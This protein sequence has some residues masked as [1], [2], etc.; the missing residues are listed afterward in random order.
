MNH[1]IFR[2]DYQDNFTKIANNDPAFDT[3][4]PIA[5]AVWHEL[6]TK[7]KNWKVI[8]NAIAKKARMS[9]YS[10]K[11]A[12]QELKKEG[13]LV[14]ERVR[15]NLGRWVE[16]AC[17]FKQTPSIP[18][19][20]LKKSNPPSEPVRSTSRNP[21]A[22]VSTAGIL[23]AL[24]IYKESNTE[25]NK[26][27][28]ISTS[29]TP[30]TRDVCDSF[31]VFETSFFE[32]DSEPEPCEDLES[33]PTISTAMTAPIAFSSEEVSPAEITIVASEVCVPDAELS[34][35]AR[36]DRQIRTY[37]PVE[38]LTAELVEIYNRIKP[39]HWGKCA[40]IGHHIPRQVAKL[41]REYPDAESL[42][43]EWLE[44]C[45]A[46]KANNFYNS[47]K[48]QNGTINFLLDP[49]K[50]DRLAQLAQAWRDRPESAKMQVAQKM[51][52]DRD[53]IPSWENPDVMLTG[54]TLIVRRAIY[55]G[56]IR[57]EDFSSADC[58]SIEY[59]QAY[60]GELF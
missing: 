10:V 31:E 3:L 41:L 22:G 4:S 39:E 40:Q 29:N 34:A 28:E 30:L 23:P 54:V 44:A 27:E 16:S 38:A 42:R 6:V 18:T 43:Q 56:Y 19:P 58:P 12:L 47:P 5:K 52:S 36:F 13:F 51:V 14:V 33:T 20:D 55:K 8:P 59:L 37:T 21:T 1:G 15:N 48:F 9:L 49:N 25:I 46:A 24:V 60:F 11:K 2:S 26:T 7:P 45:L 17:F 57:N 32:E 50:V 53:G 35:T